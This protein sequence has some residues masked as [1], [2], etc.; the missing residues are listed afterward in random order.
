MMQVTPCECKRPGWCQRHQ[1]YKDEYW[2][3]CCRRSRKLFLAWERGVG[4][5]QNTVR[6]RP[7]TVQ[8]QPCKHLGET[9]REQPCPTCKGEVRLKV[10]RCAIHE[11]CT[12][13]RKLEGPA[14]C[15][16]CDDYQAGGSDQLVQE[17][18]VSEA[19][20]STQGSPT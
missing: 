8:Q 20:A 11:Q 17:D 1:C 3:Q 7:R 2:F 18:G 12:L 6:R 9:L 14:C 15:C 19:D 5:G 4:P 10:F 16:L 13:A